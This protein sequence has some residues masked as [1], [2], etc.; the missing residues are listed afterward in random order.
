VFDDPGAVR[1]VARNRSGTLPR[2]ASRVRIWAR[3]QR[4]SS[5]RLT[6]GL[7]VTLVAAS[8][9]AASAAAAATLTGAGSTLVAPLVSVWATRF[10]AAN[11]GTTVTY[12]GVGSGAGIAYVG[13]SQVDF[14]AT[15]APLMSADGVQ[16]TGCALVPWALTATGIGYNVPGV[17]E[18]LKLTGTVLAEIYM[19]TITNWDNPQIVS[20]NKGFH[21]PN[22][23][24]SPVFRSDASGDSYTLTGFLGAV[25][26]AWKTHNGGATLAFPPTIGVGESG[27]GGVASIINSVS[28]SIGYMSVSYLITQKIH[29]ARIANAKSNYEYPNLRNI[30]AAAA[31]VRSVPSDSVIRIVN[32]PKA[33]AAAYP[34]STFSYALVHTT[35]NANS[36]LLKQWLTYCVTTARTD[37]AP[38]GFSPIPQVVQA[39]ALKTVNS[40]S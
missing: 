17:G 6:L 8:G 28:G 19:G 37:G 5:R 3:A 27:N 15:D 20:L 34:I 18:G 36:A 30:A 14:G 2:V 40:I 22:L 16:C 25:S 13:N 24:I 32:P 1:S 31:E 12:Q 7:L 23:K 10:M 11:S 35:G 26:S 38:L 21:L 9:F 39:A 29:V 33:Y 4:A